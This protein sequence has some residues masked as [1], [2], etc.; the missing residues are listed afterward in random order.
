[1]SDSNRNPQRLSPLLSS[2]GALGGF[3][4]FLGASCCV[5]PILLV[6]AG[7]ATGL[8]AR[9]AWFARWQ[10]EFFWSAAGLLAVAVIWAVWRGRPGRSFWVWWVIGAAFLAAALILPRYEIQLQTW[11]LDWTRQ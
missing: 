1:M 3:F 10:S 11:L 5:I 4:A 8:V 2:G 7:V 9:L 6:Q